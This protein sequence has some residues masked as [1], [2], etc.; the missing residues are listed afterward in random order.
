MTR[1]LAQAR[2][3][4]AWLTHTWPQLLESRLKGTPRYWI[5][6]TVGNINRGPHESVDPSVAGAPA[7]LLLDVYD[8]L[9][10]INHW[11]DDTS[12]AIAQLTGTERPWLAVCDPN[13]GWADPTGRIAYIGDQLDEVVRLEPDLADAITRE[14]SAHAHRSAALMGLIVDGQVLDADCPYC[15]KSR[16]LKNLDTPDG[17][18]IVCLSDVCRDQQ[19]ATGHTRLYGRRAWRHPDGW[20]Q[21]AKMLSEPK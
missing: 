7:P 9:C 13:G 19:D 5:G 17:P 11:A 2:R 20:T 10:D 1:H 16:V 18:T 14:A 4:L 15:H 8:A 12:D 6:G 21:L 3:D